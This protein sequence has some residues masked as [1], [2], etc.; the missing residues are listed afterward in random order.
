MSDTGQPQDSNA[1]SDIEQVKAQ[2]QFDN[3][4]LEN[5]VHRLN[6]QIGQ[7][8][9]SLEGAQRETKAASEELQTT[10]TQLEQVQQE[11]HQQSTRTSMHATQETQLRE[12]VNQMREEKRELLAQIAERR[13]QLDNRAIEVTRLNEII[14]DLRQQRANEQEE[15]AKLRSQSSVSDVSEH[16]LKQSLELAKNQ[17]KWL[18]EELAKTQTEMQQARTELAR[19]STTGRAEATRLRAEIESL[20]EQIEEMRQRNISLERQLRAK[21]ESERAIK[22]QQTEQTE[23]FRR[24]MAAQKKLCAEWE[25]TTEAAKKHVRS[26][27]DSLREL[28][29]HQHDNEERAREAVEL[30]ERRVEELEL[31]NSKLR[32]TADK[33]A[34][35]LDTANKLLHEATKSQTALLSPTATVAAKLQQRQGSQGGL[36]ITKLYT[37]KVAL[38]DQLRSANSE[39]ACLREGMEQILLEIEERGPII[40]AEREEYQLLLK[41]ADK[42]AQDLSAAREESATHADALRKLQKKHDL[43]ERQ[44]AVEQQQTRD[45]GRQVSRLLRSVEE[46]RSGGRPLPERREAPAAVVPEQDEEEH[47]N[48]VDRVITQNL[49]TFSDITELVSQNRRLL[50]TT[51]ELALQVAQEETQQQNKE[52]ESESEMKDALEQAET[53][54]DRLSLELEG[55]KTRM[56]VLERE[57]DMLKN[58]RAPEPTFSSKAPARSLS[59]SPPPPLEQEGI[60]KPKAPRSASKRVSAPVAE[61]GD[62]AP[63]SLAQ[64]QADFDTYVTEAR[65]TRAQL[66]EDLATHQAELSELRVCAGK[67]EAQSAFDAD[68]I[69]MLTRD[70]E[71]RQQEIDHLRT[72]TVRLHRQVEQYE[73]QLETHGNEMANERVELS[74]LRRQNT[75]LE[76]ECD[77]L[78]RNDERHRAEEQRLSAERSSLTQILENTTRMREEWQRASEEQVVQAR[79]RLA[80]A[81]KD[82]DA[83]R[84]ELKNV[85]DAGERAQF[86][87]DSEL[88]ELRGQ[89]QQREERASQLQDQIVAGKELQAKIQG[90]RREVE[91]ARDALQRQVAE[92][93]ERIRSQ[94]ELVQRVQGQGQA[95]SKESLLNIQL[96]DA[97]S[98]LVTLTS[99][100][101]ATRQR[102]EDYRQLATANDAALKELT[103][104]YDQ[105]KAKTDQVA[106]EQAARVAELE[107]A[108]EKATKELNECRSTLEATTAKLRSA[109]ANM[110]EQKDI[111]T[112][113]L[114]KLDAES[115]QKDRAIESLR[116]DLARREESARSLQQQYEKEVVMH[117]DVIKSALVTREKLMETRKQLDMVAGELQASRKH[118]VTLQEKLN[119]AHKKASGDVK[120]VESRLAEARRQNSLLLAHLESIG[121]EVPDISKDPEQSATDAAAVSSEGAP[122]AGTSEGSQ[123]GLRDVIVYLRRER[124]LAAAQLELSQQEAQRWRQQ[125]THT[126]QMLDDVRNELLQY[127]PIGDGSSGATHDAASSSQNPGASRRGAVDTI[128]AGE[129]PITLTA[130]QRQACRHQIEQAQLLR[131]SN[132]VLRNDLNTARR[133]LAS[134]ETELTRVRDREVPQLRSTNATLQAQLE[135]ATVQVS[136][137]EGMCEHWKQR[138]EKVLAKYEMIEPEEYEALKRDSQGLKDTVSR[139]E[140]ENSQLRSKAEQVPVEAQKAKG[141]QSEIA[142]LR[143]RIEA[144]E[145]QLAREQQATETRVKALQDELSAMETGAQA[146]AKEAAENKAKFD[147]LH[148]VF[149]KLRQQSVEK[150]EL[151]NKVIQGHEA[152]IQALNA[153][154][155]SLE[156]AQ[157]LNTESTGALAD[158]EAFKRLESEVAVLASDKDRA[159]ADYQKLASDLQQTQMALEQARAELAAKQAQPSDAAAAA[160]VGGDAAGSLAE[161]GRLQAALAASEA[162]VKEYETQLEQLKARALKYARDN[163]VLQSKAAELEKKLSESGAGEGAGLKQQLEAAQKQLAEADAKIE[164]AQNNAKKTAELR[165]RLQISK[166]NKRADDLAK[167]VEELQAKIGVLE[168]SGGSA[169]L[170]RPGEATDGPAK[171]PHV[172]EAK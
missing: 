139:L 125:N 166:A 128:P 103:D 1:V 119:E 144:L 95:V 98:Q 32:E 46:A 29:S 60:A 47:L 30:M 160:D 147:K 155:A 9:S 88:R 57:R 159:L 53:M 6:R 142:R 39:I 83:L 123:R 105:Y 115:K 70:L 79:E 138:H 61:S 112:E 31:E 44:L 69:Q 114:D 92:L 45:L 80:A 10:K 133:R 24:E 85:R 118:G 13:D 7:L 41:D 59:P 170:K 136:Q 17:V 157:P 161:I 75:L 38:E 127:T 102:A 154:I 90:E 20:G 3:S 91:V 66:E 36:N 97:R 131:E 140:Q 156:S 5:E 77:N 42:I 145:Q 94:E 2:L 153:Q 165:S 164:Q 151:S 167:Q 43:V 62:D 135:A 99:E 117:A 104:T 101:D 52:G 137:L 65:K 68:R 87:F 11:L 34:A 71:A 111:Y 100:L 67:A 113:R 146:A 163:K 28:E 51:R 124:D 169:S 18:D 126:Q 33:L 86:K 14:Q 55:T 106:A 81:Y 171:K 63:G 76:A 122:A 158:T 4:R 120:E 134:I 132:S 168:G 78:R 121:H 162:K 48:E 56:S 22:E 72:A 35:D 73:K 12:Q 107:S 54:L 16:M 8:K 150:L 23:Q 15:L 50:R 58:M 84:D 26:V 172:E 25:R 40:A 109:Q 19:S 129:G 148:G 96:Q 82:A 64:L 49:V 110:S 116:G 108:L 21:A 93:E 130:A 143:Q 149:Q 152:T 141:L 74:K 27:E 37:E 89:I